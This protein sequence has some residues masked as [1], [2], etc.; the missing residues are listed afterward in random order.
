[1]FLNCDITTLKKEIKIFNIVLPGSADKRQVF[2]FDH[3]LRMKMLGKSSMT[4]LVGHMNYSL[5]YNFAES[6]AAG[7]VAVDNWV[8]DN[9]VGC[10]YCSLHRRHSYSLS[11]LLGLREQD[12]MQLL[13][14]S[15]LHN[16]DQKRC[17]KLL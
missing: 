14:I 3:I 8:V 2:Q 6:F 9:F 5:G 12:P 15:M 4:A 11:R 17:L 7:T 13:P 1:M 16:P 10:C